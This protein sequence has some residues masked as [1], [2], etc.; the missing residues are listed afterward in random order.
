MERKI[1]CKREII[2]EEKG[3]C[4]MERKVREII[5]S[6][7]NH[8]HFLFMRVFFFFVWGNDLK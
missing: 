6:P 2:Q 7:N 3:N 1:N 4:K 8:G 5:F